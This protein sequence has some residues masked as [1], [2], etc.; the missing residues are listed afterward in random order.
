MLT[1]DVV[2]DRVA[3]VPG[4]IGVVLFL[5]GAIPVNAFVRLP[6]KALSYRLS[7]L[8]HRHPTHIEIAGVPPTLWMT[9]SLFGF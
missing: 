2:Q 6:A 7:L 4:C 3:L 1:R 9:H 8:L 5:L